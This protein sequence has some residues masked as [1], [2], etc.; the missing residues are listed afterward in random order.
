MKL[1]RQQADNLPSEKL[2]NRVADVEIDEMWSYVAQEK[3]SM[4]AVA[5]VFA[6]TPTN[7]GLLS[8][9]KN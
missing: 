6:E 9:Q 2:P 7:A 8:R 5:G 3:E 1:I 4:L